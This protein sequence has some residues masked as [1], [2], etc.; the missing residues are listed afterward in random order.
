MC[1]FEEFDEGSLKSDLVW[2]GGVLFYIQLIDIF[3]TSYSVI[4][5]QL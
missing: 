5:I 1:E 4:S 3:V 2:G